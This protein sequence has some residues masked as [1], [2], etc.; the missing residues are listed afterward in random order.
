MREEITTR[1]GVVLLVK[2]GLTDDG[3]EVSLQ[4]EAG[5]KCLLHW[6]LRSHSEASWQM[7]PESVWPEGSRPFDKVALQTPFLWQNGHGRL[8]IR[9][10]RSMDFSFIEFALVFAE[11][12]RWDNNSG[13]N[14]QIKIP[15]PDR[16]SVS[17]MGALMRK[18]KEEPLLYE[19]THV[20]ENQGL[21]AVSV[22]ENEEGYH[23][24]LITDLPG[25]LILHWGLARQ[26]RH[27]WTLPPPSLWP[28]GTTV[29][30]EKA[31]QSPFV[32]KGEYRELSLVFGEQEAPMGISFVLK[33][34]RRGRWSK[35]HG[36]NFFIPVMVPLDLEASLGDP[37][38]ARL[39][40]EIIE[41][42]MRPHSWTLMHRFN[43]CYELLDRVRQSIDGL[44]LI[45]VWLRYSAIRQLDWQRDYNTKPRELSHAMDRLTVKLADRYKKEPAERELI[46]L[47]MTTMGRGGQGQRVRDE[48]LNIMHRHHIKEVSGHFMEEWHQKLHNNTTPDDVV[49]CEAY[50]EFLKNNG[51]LD[52]FYRTLKEGGVT[53]ERLEGYERPIRSHPDFIPH[54]KDALIHDFEQFL[55]ILKEVHSATDLGAAIDGAR[56]L[57]DTQMQGLMDFLWHHGEDQEAPVTTLV[58]KITKGRQWLKRQMEEGHGH[59]RDLLFL[60]LALEDFLRLVV[61][62]NLHVRSSEDALVALIAMVVE[63]LLLSKDDEELSHC[64]AHW[65]SLRG[66][67]GVEEKWALEA[68][69]VLDRLG[70]A[71]GTMIDRY[72]QLFE[73]KARFLGEAFRAESWT[74]ALFTDEVVRGRPA[75]AL[76]TL[77]GQ[78][79]PV[80]RDKA[81]LGNWQVVSPGRETGRVLVVDKLISVQGNRYSE[82]TV[83]VTNNVS[84]EEEI[85]E[86]VTAIITEDRT[87]IVS[88]VAI[89]ARNAHVVLATSYDQ[90]VMAQL[91]SLKGRW[92]SVSTNVAGEVEVKEGRGEA[93][94]PVA[95]SLTAPPVIFRPS[96]TSY[97]VSAEG[98]TEKNVGGKSHNLKRL[99]GE[100]PDWIHVPSSVAL[101][102]RVFER[103]LSQESNKEIAGRYEEL[104]RKADQAEEGSREILH[105]LRGTVTGL[106]APDEM[107]SALRLVMEQAGL[108]WPEDWQRAWRCIKAVWGS[109]WNQ[110]AYLSRRARKTPHKDLF[111]AVLI[112]EVVEADYSF[113]IHTVN[114]VTGDR[115]EV[116][117]EVV[118]GLG[119]T[120]VGNYPGK[121]FSFTCR[122]GKDVPRLLAFP[123]KS[124]GLFGRGLIF[125]SDSNGEDL[126]GY[127]G[128]GLYES[129]ML[130]RPHQVC[131][132]Y[133]E[134]L[135]LKDDGF[136]HEFL[137]TVARIGAAVE[138]ASGSAQD[139][140]GA[141]AGGKY[142]V[143]QTRPQVGIEDG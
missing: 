93:E 106:K 31:A 42:E 135:L 14:Y 52:T 24:R 75:F 5:K 61:E 63:N 99:R 29:F 70:R 62:R 101:P 60:D 21:V 10:D 57:F 118:P 131:L 41:K 102:F 6:G 80:L 127:A 134:E 84:G 33:E 142:W 19:H 85:P 35:D 74:I 132:D 124:M 20:L 117:A 94:T 9:L 139:I 81:H 25:P 119:E 55:G 69:A 37:L 79:D 16:L 116:F 121:A 11:E 26:S 92:V 105:E 8:M 18:G 77:V 7:P 87:D 91:R 89:R 137:A 104:S 44:A 36:G 78:I 88:H 120:L 126:A 13:S 140:E 112:Q 45:F 27:E 34:T 138:Q 40:D 64:L 39:A 109:K 115:G 54:L 43:L 51:H 1:S 23:V 48:V 49:L 76:S 122:K 66:R 65:E 72:F 123:S 67:A 32:D 2:K 17:G 114:P 50:I 68:N 47:I 100:L 133:T 22:G 56:H 86:G 12:D 95:P 59:T 3:I 107:V 130:E 125:R 128:A 38:L 58:E 108:P 113:V 97:A 30:Q 15:R 136:Q 4:M 103:V 82:P 110:R 73:P 83:I 98:F 141:Y 53:K 143:V 111:M 96:F 71:L 129:V 90:E 28:V 46:R